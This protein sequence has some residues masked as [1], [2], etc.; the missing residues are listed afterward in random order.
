MVSLFLRIHLTCNEVKT[1]ME[2]EGRREGEREREKERER[3]GRE[4]RNSL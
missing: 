4:E 3:E 1:G 2:G